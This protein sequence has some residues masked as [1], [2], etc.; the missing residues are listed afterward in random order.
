MRKSNLALAAVAAVGVAAAAPAQAQ[1]AGSTPGF[2][3]NIL[4]TLEVPGGKYETLIGVSELKPNGHLGRQR[5]PG[6][7]AGYVLKGSGSIIV[8]GGPTIDLKPGSSYRL[9]AGAVHQTHA[10]PQ[11]T[12]LVV[13]WVVEKGKPL[14]SP[15]K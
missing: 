3:R 11:G 9:P 10:G 1:P 2:S 8:D 14:Q 4:Q 7:E 15:T 12:K 13:V 5:H 6:Q